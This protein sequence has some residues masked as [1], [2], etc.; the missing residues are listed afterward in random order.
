MFYVTPS[1]HMLRW[2]CQ[3]LLRINAKSGRSDNECRG[4]TRIYSRDKRLQYTPKMLLFQSVRYSGNEALI[5]TPS[6]YIPVTPASIP[7][8]LHNWIT[9]QTHMKRTTKRVLE[10]NI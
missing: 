2:S 9:G 10:N 8:F 1:Y 6:Y 7:E 4:V 3:Q 5:T